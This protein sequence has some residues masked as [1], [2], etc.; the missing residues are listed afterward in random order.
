MEHVVLCAAHRGRLNLLTGLLQFPPEILFRKLRGLS[1]FSD[2]TGCT[3]DVISHL[4]SSVDLNVDR[5]SFH[6]TLLRNPSHLEMV[7]PVSMG[8]TR[9]VMQ[10]IKE[11]AYGD[12]ESAQWS[13]KV[14]NVQVRKNRLRREI[15]ATDLV[16]Y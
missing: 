16:Y 10:A 2:A 15:G 11:S 7:N 1:E 13:D 6:V 9:G 5:K 4:T 3:G 12:D 14:I 8:K